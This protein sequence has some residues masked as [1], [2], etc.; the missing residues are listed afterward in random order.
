MK[1]SK[2]IVF[3]I[4]VLLLNAIILGCLGYLFFVR[5]DI[6]FGLKDAFSERTCENNLEITGIDMENIKSISIKDIKDGKTNIRYNNSLLLINQEHLVDNTFLPNIKNYKNTSLMVD[7]NVIMPLSDMLSKAL[8]HTGDKILI[9][10]SYR[11]FN[12]QVEIFNEDKKTAAIPGSSEHQSG[13]ALDLYVKENAGRKFISTDGGKWIYNNCWNYGF[14]VRY[15]LLKEN[16]T[17]IPY[18]PWHIRYVGLPHSKIMYDNK[19]TLEEYIN[20][21][22]IDMFY[23]YGNYIISRQKPINNQIIIP[24]NLKNVWISPDNMGFYFITGE[25]LP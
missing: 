11:D 8:N 15:P 4:T 16:I 17:N 20:K 23:K 21:F 19:Y 25:I 24:S 10:S 9:M 13:L 12:H 6:V 3:A 22:S 2:K 18:E 1:L 14:V 5:D 7:E